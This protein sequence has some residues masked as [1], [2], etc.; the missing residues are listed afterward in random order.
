VEILVAAGYL[1]LSRALNVCHPSHP[2][3]RG[4][5]FIP[6]FVTAKTLR[7]RRVLA[8]R[9]VVFRNLKVNESADLR[10]LEPGTKC[11]ICTRS[12]AVRPNALFG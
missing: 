4:W 2:A 12:G 5:G 10:A 7:C 3:R 6:D 11:A 8:V 9:P 1:R